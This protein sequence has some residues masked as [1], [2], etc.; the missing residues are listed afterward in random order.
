MNKINIDKKGYIALFTIAILTGLILIIVM[1]LTNIIVSKR[2]ISRNAVYSSQSYY[3]AESAIEDGIL[4]VMNGYNYSPSGS[5]VLDGADIVLDITQSGDVTTI[6]SY[7][8]YSSNKRKVRTSLTVNQDDIAFHYGVQVGRGGLTMGN[9]SEIEGNIYSDGP[10]A[11]GGSGSKIDGDAFVATG[12]SLD[13]D[14]SVYNTDGDFGKAS[15]IID[16]AQSFKPTVSGDLSQIS[17]Y[18]KKNGN[19][20][21]K[22]IKIFT[23]DGTGGANSGSPTKTELTS[24]TFDTS[25][26]GSS[27]GWVDFSFSSPASLVAGSWYWVVIDISESNS[28]YFTIAKDSNKGNGNGVSK[29]SPDWNAGSPVWTED[30]GD[31]NFKIWMGGQSTYL[32]SVIVANDAHAHEIRTS[33]ICGDAYYQ[34]IDANSLDFVDNPTSAKCDL[35]LTSG[36]ANSGAADPPVEALPISDSNIADWKSDAEAGGFLDTALCIVDT[37]TTI[38]AGVLDC[39]GAPG[40][41]FMPGGGITITLNGTVWVKGNII[42]SNGIN[43]RLSSGYGSKSGII[44]ADNPGNESTSGKI[45]V[46]NNVNI[47]GS[48]G[49]DLTPPP[50]CNPPTSSYI[51]MLS[52]HDSDTTNAITISNNADGAIFYAHNGIADV[53]NNADLKEVTAYQLNLEENAKVTYESGLANASFTSGPGGGWAISGWNEFE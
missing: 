8:N 32:E 35:P 16:V 5:F 34:V 48:G 2:K 29:Y 19:P 22:T 49:F 24:D 18:I 25:K 4:R 9:N 51:L 36:T 26:I 20:T 27:Y 52:T 7:A 3:S 38:N 12:M 31:F 11:G 53:S 15:P 47:C 39:T 45:T 42:I 40:G 44:I 43:V 6:E 10:I 33:Y 14:W 1:A 41:A 13:H 50:L 30:T 46:E 37:D 17:L 28:K 23:D 21:D